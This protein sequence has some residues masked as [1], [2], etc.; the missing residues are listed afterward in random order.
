MN[1]S[2][3][4]GHIKGLVR[5][6]NIQQYKNDEVFAKLNRQLEG[7]L[8]SPRFQSIEET[9]MVPI[10]AVQQERKLRQALERLLKKIQKNPA[11]PAEVKSDIAKSHRETMRKYR[12]QIENLHRTPKQAT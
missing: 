1:L 6:I 3:I 10:I 2:R 4:K 8:N 11:F 9:K 12:K 5:H 7:L